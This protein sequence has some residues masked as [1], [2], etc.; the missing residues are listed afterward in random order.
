MFA[1]VRIGNKQ[2]KV[3]DHDVILVDKIEGEVGDTVTFNDVLLVQEEKKTVV[4]TPLVKGTAVTVKILAKEKGKK[5]AVRRFKSK[6]RYRRHTGFRANLTR[7]EVVA[8][9]RA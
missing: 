4:G 6:V 2:Y 1:I 7:L 8:I 3:A 9:T 5:I